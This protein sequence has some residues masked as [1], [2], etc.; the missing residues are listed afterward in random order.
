MKILRNIL[1]AVILPLNIITAILAL[2][3]AYGEYISPLTIPYPA[4]LGLAFPIVVIVN[5]LFVFVWLFVK[6]L[7]ILIPLLSTLACVPAIWKYSPVHFDGDYI[8]DNHPGFTLLCYNVYYFSD[9]EQEA[10]PDAPLP[11]YNRTLQNI[12]DADADIVMAQ[13]APIPQNV[14]WRKVT[15][16][17]LRQLQRQY[18]YC[19]SGHNSFVMSKYPLEAILDTVYSTSASTHVSRVD[20]NGHKVTLFNNHLESIGL[21][22]NDKDAYREITVQPDSIRSN[23]RNIRQMVRKFVNAFE[24]RAVQVHFVD[25]LAASIGGNII[26]CGDINDTPNSYAY[27]ILSK[28]RDDAYL[29]L[30]CGPGFT[31]RANRMWVRID[32]I[33]YEG[34]LIPRNF[35][36]GNQRSSDHF[37]LLVRFDWK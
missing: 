24:L 20:I 12:L 28:S 4:L 7:F 16:G 35:R 3:A 17:Q 19:V 13:E 21:D 31:Y 30:G 26:L 25:S 11:D 37:P 27:R 1:A 9:V 14:R 8:D 22:Q 34:D 32:H 36:L 15:E 5:V 6:P 2:L 33:F 18:P 23:W 10:Y 29:Q